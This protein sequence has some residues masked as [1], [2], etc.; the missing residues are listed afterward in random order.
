MK[1]LLMVTTAIVVISAAPIPLHA[2]DVGGPESGVS[3]I[4]SFEGGYFFNASPRNAYFDPSDLILDSLSPLQPGAGGGQ[5]RVELGQRL[6]RSWDYKFGL[7]AIIAGDDESS[8][9]VDR[10]TASQSLAMQIVDGEVGYHLGALDSADLRL[11]AGLRGLHATNDLAWEEAGTNRGA[12]FDDSVSALGPRLGVDLM[13]PFGG[14]R[15]ALVGSAAGSV[16]F[17]SMESTIATSR[18]DPAPAEIQDDRT[19]WNVEA[20]AGV[21]MALGANA[22][23]T[24]GYRAA[25][26]SNLVEDRS[27]LDKYGNFSDDGSSSV[28]LHGPFARLTVEIP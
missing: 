14:D 9:S 7:S 19:I 26:F 17:G 20:M 1:A 24:L 23:L 11:F 25:E 12:S 2:A 16:L 18:N 3:T 5:G 28:L 21:S 4:L 10:T 6:N 8:S 13:L 22:G 15:F 27:D